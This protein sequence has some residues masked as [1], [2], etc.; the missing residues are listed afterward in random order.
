ML[1]LLTITAALVSVQAETEA[2]MS[3]AESLAR[4]YMVHYSAFDLDAMETYLAED[5]IFSDPTA[6]GEGLGEDGLYHE[7]RAHTMEALREFDA[8]YGVLELG[9]EW[10]TVF[11]SNGRVV[12]TGHVNAR[13]PT[14]DPDQHFRWR[15]EQVTVITVRDGQIIRQDDF[16]NYAGPDQGMVPAR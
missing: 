11:E 9:F 5:V 15:A 2:Q 13:Y 6:L 12:F 3:A 10:D 7:G 1:T 4:E 8:Q 16:A 14:Q